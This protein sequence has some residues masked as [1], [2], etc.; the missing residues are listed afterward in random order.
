M[1][2]PWTTSGR[3]SVR[4]RTFIGPLNLRWKRCRR[5]KSEGANPERSSGGGWISVARVRA[6]L[7]GLVAAAAV[8]AWALV[9]ACLPDLDVVVVSADGG[10]ASGSGSVCGDGRIDPDAGE[11]CDPGSG[12]PVGCARCKLQCDD[13]AGIDPGSHHC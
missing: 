2:P 10:D 3:G 7:P 1:R 9:A 12:P 8:L 5:R 6:S 13:D 4:A 11:E